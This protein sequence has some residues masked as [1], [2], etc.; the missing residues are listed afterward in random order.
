MRGL[1]VSIGKWA[2]QHDPQASGRGKQ[3]IRDPKEKAGVLSVF[4][5]GTLIMH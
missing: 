5:Q 4:S 3:R 1:R 2:R